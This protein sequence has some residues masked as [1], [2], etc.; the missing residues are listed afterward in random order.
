VVVIFLGG[1]VA[2][3]LLYSLIPGQEVWLYG[4]FPAAYGLIGAFT[5]ILWARLGMEHA[6][7]GRAFGFIG[8][9]VAFQIVFWAIGGGALT[10]L[11]DLAGFA[12]GFLLAFLVVPGGPARLLAR[13]R[14]R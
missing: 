3:G 14:N 7:R 13:V 4:A 5:F 12:A 6:H 10:W 9:L 1:A 2:G 11:A 8:V